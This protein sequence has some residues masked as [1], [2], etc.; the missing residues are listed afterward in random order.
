MQKRVDCYLETVSGKKFDF[1]NPKNKDID[2]EDIAHSL[3]MQCRFTGHSWKF[4]SIAEHSINASRMCSPE[5]KLW[6]LLHDASEAYLTDVASPVKPHL[7]NY[8]PMEKVIMDAICLKFGLPTDM[9]EEVHEAD[10]VLLKR[11]AFELMHSGGTDW[12]KNDVSRVFIKKTP[13]LG[14]DPVKAKKLFL[15]KFYEIINES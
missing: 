10:M 9:P 13:I 3:S 6:A 15:D 7:T 8:K 14:Y 4:Y 5:N 1:I 11:E 2:I 12:V